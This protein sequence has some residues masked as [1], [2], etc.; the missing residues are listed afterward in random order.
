MIP[1]SIHPSGES[2]RWEGTPW[3][4]EDGPAVVNGRVLATQVALLALGTVLLDG[5]PKQGSRHEAY[6][7]LAGGLLRQGDG[8][9]GCDR[10]RPPPAPGGQP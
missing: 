6:L 5:W 8:I 7:A 3:G 1:P 9:L 4:G 10:S 2:Y